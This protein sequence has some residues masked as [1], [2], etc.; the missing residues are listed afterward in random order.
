HSLGGTF[1]GVAPNP[2]T[3]NRLVKEVAEVVNRPLILPNVPKGLM[4]LILGEMSFILFASQRV[5]SKKIEEEGFDF[6][7][8]NICSALEN[9]IQSEEKK[10]DLYKKEFV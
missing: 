7:Y 4:R 6:Y 2:V 9:V 5:S 1:N 8:K 3:N 10:S